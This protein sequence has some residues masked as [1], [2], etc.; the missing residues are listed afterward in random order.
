MPGKITLD[1]GTTKNGEGRAFYLPPATPDTLKA[2]DEGT[3][4]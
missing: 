1:P 2:W 4:A 3:R